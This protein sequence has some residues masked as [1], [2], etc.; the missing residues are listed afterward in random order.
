MDA[1]REKKESGALIRA[2][3]L[4][5][6]SSLP[7][8]YMIMSALYLYSQWENIANRIPV[9]YDFRFNVDSWA[10]KGFWGVYGLLFV[11]LIAE[12][13]MP[14]LL[15]VM[16]ILP[17]KYTELIENFRFERGRAKNVFFLLWVMHW[18]ALEFCYISITRALLPHV[19]HA[20]F[21]VEGLLAILAFLFLLPFYFLLRPKKPFLADAGEKG[22]IGYNPHWKL[23]DLFYWNPDDPALIVERRYGHGFTPNLARPLVWVLTALIMLLI[24][25]PVVI[26]CIA[27]YFRC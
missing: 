3:M 11:G 8:I 22:D 24:M 15:Y 17:S 16:S 19:P 18:V 21:I 20:F 9:H 23:L 26:L 2:Y 5:F 25:G 14:I 4:I 27:L 7:F 12:A 10:D 6:L 13:V 1:Q